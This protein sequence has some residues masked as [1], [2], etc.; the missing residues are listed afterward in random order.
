MPYLREG[1][2]LDSLARAAI[3]QYFLPILSGRLEVVVRDGAREIVISR[4]SIRDAVAEISWPQR[5]TKEELFR[6]IGPCSV[7]NQS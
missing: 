7:A 3:E 2:D 4:S 5:R 6:L 1:V